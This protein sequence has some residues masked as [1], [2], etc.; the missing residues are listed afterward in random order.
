MF[1]PFTLLLIGSLFCIVSIA[2]QPVIAPAPAWVM[3]IQPDYS[4]KPA[5]KEI[6]DGFYFEL[7]D[8][9]IHIPNETRY[10]HFT[11]YIFNESGVQNASEI[12]VDY[13]PE[14]QKV[15]FHYLNLIRNGKVVS[16]LKPQQIR[17]VQEESS[18]EKFMYNNEKRAFVIL[19]G[20]RKDDRI[21]V[22]YSII[23]FN[24]VFKNYFSSTNYFT[25]GTAISNY[26]LTYHSQPDKKLQLHLFNSAPAPVVLNRNGLIVHHWKQPVLKAWESQSGVPD[27][28]DNFPYGTLTEFGSWKEIVNWGLQTF[29]SYEYPLSESLKKKIAELR[30]QSRGD[31]D[32]YSELAIRMVQDQIRYLGFEIGVNTHQPHDPN[33]VFR[34]GFGDCKD[35]A[36]LLAKILQAENIQAY[37]A[38]VNTTEKS[39]VENE[40]P[41]TGAFNHAIVAIERS[42]NYIFVDAT[43]S[44]QRGAVIN[45]YVPDY[46]KALLLKP[47]ETEFQSIEQGAPNYTKVEEE[48]FVKFQGQG[49]SSLKVTTYYSGGTADMTRDYL[50]GTSR[51]DMAKQY[52]NYYAAI[53]D[54]IK[55]SGDIK[56]NDDSVKNSITVQENY[57]IPKIWSY[58][59]E[60][61]DEMTVFAKAIYEKIPSPKNHLAGAP[62]A[63]SE[64]GELN[65]KL[66]VIMPEEWS[67]PIKPLHIRNSSY[68]FDF[69]PSFQGKE[70]YLSYSFKT[71]KDHITAE[72]VT[73][74]KT[75]YKKIENSL[76]WDLYKNSFAEENN[77]AINPSKGNPGN[78]STSVLSLFILIGAILLMRNFNKRTVAIVPPD[79]PAKQIGGW[80][81]ILGLSM[82]ITLV[83]RVTSYFSNN[84][85]NPETYIS[86][87][88]TGGDNLMYAGILEMSLNIILIVLNAA[89]IFWYVKRRDIFPKFFITYIISIVIGNL[90]ILSAYNIAGLE[91]LNP[92][93]KRD[94][95][96]QIGQN[97]AYGSIWIPY[98]LFSE[99]VKQ[100]F[101]HSY[102]NERP[103]NYD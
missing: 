61:R 10:S 66:K 79:E 82:I 74:F 73:A 97:V 19:E 8:Q 93:F 44:H 101:V 102:E 85:L 80:T 18:S 21:D 30:L 22:A 29:K 53:Y 50:A 16:R 91:T 92:G 103:Q 34:Q 28:Y 5:E 77:S 17:V 38:L 37:V 33:Q 51:E 60:G 9:Q 41:S 45:T 67:F 83:L 43:I 62:L 95:L 86:L 40:A 70:I 63:L 72:D 90:L 71:L 42:H 87:R 1:K 13:S 35:K 96:L 36:L 6:S 20:T 4:K 24:P 11:K 75:D 89:L 32:L 84:Y 56:I 65:Y 15:V 81:A 98:V 54:S 49:N 26:F 14:Y 100:T 23:G 64:P 48:L 2:Q 12:S 99:K 69:T 94:F 78:Y 3:D 76:Q 31:K 46:G 88:N 25:R 39:K 7:S 52:E 27:W 57:F 47:G 55:L 59:D 58:S 68:E